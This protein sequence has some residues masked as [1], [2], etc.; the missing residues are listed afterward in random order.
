MALTKREAQ[1]IKLAFS[2][3]K[4]YKIRDNDEYTK[5]IY[6]ELA[7]LLKKKGINKISDLEIKN[8]SK[9]GG[10]SSKLIYLNKYLM[11]PKRDE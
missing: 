5:K 8:L 4:K 3:E 1:I 2:I 6:L 11:Y 10:F 9:L 7:N